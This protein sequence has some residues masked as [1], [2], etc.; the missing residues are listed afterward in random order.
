MLHIMGFDTCIFTLHAK[1]FETLTVNMLDNG[2]PL[3]KRPC[4]VRIG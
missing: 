4:A 2:S 3:V 1:H